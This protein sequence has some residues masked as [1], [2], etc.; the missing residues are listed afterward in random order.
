MPFAAQDP[1]VSEYNQLPDSEALAERV[2]C[3]LQVPPQ[4]ALSSRRL[5]LHR[6]PPTRRAPHASSPPSHDRRSAGIAAR[7]A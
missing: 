1:D 2:R 4:R 6:S 7:C 5:A 3:C